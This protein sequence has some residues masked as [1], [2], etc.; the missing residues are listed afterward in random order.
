MMNGFVALIKVAARVGAIGA[1]LTGIGATA[2]GIR[3]IWHTAPEEQSWQSKTI[4]STLYA[5]HMGSI[6]LTAAVLLGATDV[7]APVAT[8]IVCS[9]ALLKNVADLLVEKTNYIGLA[10]KHWDLE[11]QFSARNNDFETNLTLVEDLK[12]TD[13]TIDALKKQ[14]KEHHVF[15]KQTRNS[16]ILQTLLHSL[17]DQDNVLTAKN[18]ILRSFFVKVRPDS[19]DPD[20]TIKHLVQEAAQLTQAGEHQQL[21]RIGIIQF[22]CIKYKRVAT[23]LKEINLRL[24]SLPPGAQLSKNRYLLKRK[25]ELEQRLTLLRGGNVDCFPRGFVARLETK[26]PAAFKKALQEYLKNKITDI[27]QKIT[28]QQL[29]LIEKKDYLCRPIDFSPLVG[30]VKDVSAMQNKLWLAKLN[31]NAK[32]NNVDL[33]MASAIMALVLALIPHLEVSRYLHPL[34][35]SIGVVAGVVSLNDLYKCYQATHRM[36]DIESKKMQQFILQMKF[37]IGKLGDSQLRKILTKQLEDILQ[38]GETVVPIDPDQLVVNHARMAKLTAKR[39]IYQ[40]SQQPTS[41]V[42]KVRTR[43][44]SSRR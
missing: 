24:G 31:E 6:S 25:N 32:S 35:L 44:S 7:T 19:F 1:K 10:R 29:L 14:L 40:L 27:A 11:Q 5:L 36:S 2:F 33:G 4:L 28:E 26:S 43:L 42:L 12:E 17:K 16:T 13:D 41:P 30:Q 37:Q 39:S 34:M 21:S 38:D 9:T 20:A 8:A 22:Q 23:I 18:K 15:L 3:Q